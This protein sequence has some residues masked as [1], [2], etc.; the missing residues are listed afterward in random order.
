MKNI[1]YLLSALILST[2]VSCMKI[3]NY[4]AP[5]SQISGKVIDKTTG[6]PIL[7][8]P[9]DFQIRIWE[10]SWSDNPT[11]QDIPVM[12]DGTYN[13]SRLFDARYDLQP[14]NGPFWPVDPVENL[15]LSGTL[16]Q[17]FEVTPYLQIVDFDYTLT[18]T[19]LSVTCRLKA[20]ITENLPQVLD[21]RTFLSLSQY[22]GDNSRLGGEY[23]DDKYKVNV[24]KPWSEIG[25]MTTGEGYETYVIND[26]PLKSGLTFY[27]RVGARVEDTY[28]KYN[29]SEI[30][31]VK[32]P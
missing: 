7:T 27:L 24:N 20:P 29:Y 30:V 5:E 16:T 10:V 6:K 28:R 9:N 23:N 2:A 26:I 4:D 25:N 32:V 12:Q 18:G 15:T 22:C 14:Y 8:C 31:E 19:T 17:D 13:D 11:P 3:D 21:I 1:Y